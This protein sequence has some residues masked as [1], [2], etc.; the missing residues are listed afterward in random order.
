MEDNVFSGKIIG[1][2]I[3]VHQ[4]PGP[5]LFKSA[6]QECLFYELKN[7]GLKVIKEMPLP[8]I[9]EEVYLECGFRIDSFVEHQFVIEV[10]SVDALYDINMAQVLTYL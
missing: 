3:K 1:C 5:G 7:S 9:Y 2:A 4:V 6:Y 8:L 10:K